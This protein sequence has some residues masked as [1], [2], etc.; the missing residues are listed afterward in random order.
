MLC[1]EFIRWFHEFSVATNLQIVRETEFDNLLSVLLMWITTFFFIERIRSFVVTKLVKLFDE[2][3]TGHVIYEFYLRCHHPWI[4]A[5]AQ[6]QSSIGLLAIEAVEALASVTTAE[7]GPNI[8]NF[9]SFSAWP[10][11]G[12]WRSFRR[13]ETVFS[14]LA[15]N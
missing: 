2:F 14:K 1:N 3:V 7:V 5:G 12:R 8:T 15:M 4:L 13:V 6:T 11:R 9:P 10:H